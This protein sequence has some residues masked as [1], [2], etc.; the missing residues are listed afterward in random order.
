MS[1]G[2]LY[3]SAPAPLATTAG[4]L[5]VAGIIGAALVLPYTLTLTGNALSAAALRRGIRPA[6]LIA[7]SLAQTAILVGLATFAGLWA[8]RKVGLGVPILDALLTGERV[9]ERAVRGLAPAFGLGIAC[10]FVIILLDL[11]VFAP[12]IPRQIAGSNPAAWK[13]ALASFYGAIDEELLLRLGLLSLLA[14]GLQQLLHAVGVGGSDLAPGTFWAVNVIA[15]VAFGL[16][17]LPATAAITALTPGVITRAIVLNGLAGIT[18]GWLY[19]RTGLEAA[20]VAH[21]GADLILHVAAPLLQ[22]R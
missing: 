18:F 22:S 12:L 4:V 17:H 14:L 21:F 8:A 11:K 10:A 16:G 3:R 9:P 5:W 1:A 15:A 13:G 19:W 2:T 7:M 20:M 6:T